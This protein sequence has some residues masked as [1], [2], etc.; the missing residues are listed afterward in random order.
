M[1]ETQEIGKNKK[2]L[3]ISLIVIIVIVLIVGLAFYFVSKEKSDE[4]LFRL[5]E[6]Y[7]NLKTKTSYCFTTTLDDNNKMAYAK[8]DGKACVDTIYDGNESKFI[9]KDGNSYLIMEDRKIYYKYNNNEA[10]L[11]KIELAL[12][13]IKDL[14]HTNGEEKINNKKYKYEEYN[15]LTEFAIQDTSEISNGE[16]IKT[17]FY[18]DKDKLIYIKTIIGEKEELLKVDISDSVDNNLFEIPSDYKEI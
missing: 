8:K 15:V 9:I 2:I 6:L 17:R 18:F 11:N 12:E 7:E 5:N 14:E 13:E 3:L 16:D 4:N 10:D 1:S